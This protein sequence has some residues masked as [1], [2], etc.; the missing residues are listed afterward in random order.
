[1]I[2][3]STNMINFFEQVDLIISKLDKLEKEVLEIKQTRSETS[4]N[5]I[6]DIEEVSKYLYRSKNSIYK[7]AEKAQ[8]PYT[9]KSGKLY[10]DKED[11]NKWL[12]S[13]KRQTE[14]EIEDNALNKL[15]NR[16]TAQR[17]ISN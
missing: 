4:G 16:R 1:M 6:M 15:L 13:G 2:S 7:L 3:E 11:I 17:R 5:N 14:S 8:I 9:K 12:K 10:F